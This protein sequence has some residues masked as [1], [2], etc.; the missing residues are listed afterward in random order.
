MESKR[1]QG[2][3]HTPSWVPSSHSALSEKLGE[4]R[5]TPSPCS[6]PVRLFHYV[7]IFGLLLLIGCNDSHKPSLHTSDFVDALRD[8][9]FTTEIIEEVDSTQA[10]EGKSELSLRV[11]DFDYKLERF[12]L[13]PPQSIRRLRAGKVGIASE[14]N[15]TAYRFEN[16]NLVL[17]SD[18]RPSPDH[19]EIFRGI[20]PPMDVRQ[21]GWFLYPLGVCLMMSVFIFVERW[22]AL[23]R[24]RIIPKH[25]EHSLLSGRITEN[26]ISNRS[27]AERLAGVAERES[28][29]LDILRAYVRLEISRME[30]GV[31]LLEIIVGIAPLIGLL[32]TVSGLVRVFSGMPSGS[33]A[34]DASAFSGG[35]AM[36]LLTTIIG[37]TIAIPSLVGHSLLS[38]AIDNRATKLEWL[39]ERL[40]DSKSSDKNK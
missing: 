27:A 30:R 17:S 20:R 18:R 5:P 24:S 9:G 6:T 21:A 29:T 35:I 32:G 2:A 34:P 28:P 1:P 26:Q 16:L 13:S 40:Y 39:A 7:I 36:A 10:L 8:N 31:F 14:G 19:L 15:A 25:I 33:G 12:D 38:R 4:M 37:L 3:C 22:F 11:D 23:R